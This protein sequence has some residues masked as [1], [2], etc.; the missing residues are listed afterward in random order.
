ML[1]TA[2]VQEMLAT[3]TPA[4]ERELLVLIGQA[5]ARERE[6]IARE[7]GHGA[8]DRPPRDH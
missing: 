2:T 1:Y 3:L 6:P 5:V 4:E 7:D 8:V